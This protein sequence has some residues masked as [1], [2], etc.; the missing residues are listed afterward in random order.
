MQVDTR[1]RTSRVMDRLEALM[2]MAAASWE[3]GRYLCYTPTEIRLLEDDLGDQ[4]LLPLPMRRAL[5]CRPVGDMEWTVLLVPGLAHLLDESTGGFGGVW[6]VQS[7][8]A[9]VAERLAAMLTQADQWASGESIEG[10]GLL[11]IL[12][13]ATKTP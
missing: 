7:A 11:D 1:G 6:P 3:S 2:V 13:H 9:A 5:A 8:T 10:P 4:L 12:M